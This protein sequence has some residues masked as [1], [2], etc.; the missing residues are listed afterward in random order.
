MRILRYFAREIL[1]A[2]IVSFLVFF[3]LF[4]L[5]QILLL[6]EEILKRKAPV[7]QVAILILASL[8]SI[9]ALTAPFA[10]LL[11][12]LLSMGRL[13]GDREIL[14]AQASGIPHRLLFLPSLILGTV[15]SLGSYL[16]NDVLLP[17]GAI[18]FNKV[19]RELIFSTPELELGSYSVKFYKNFFIVTGKVEGSTVHGI[20]LL[21]RTARDDQQLITAKTAQLMNNA[22]FP[23]V[24]TLRFEDVVGIVPDARR[25]GAYDYYT[26][27]RLDYNIVLRDLVPSAPTLGPKEMRSFDLARQISIKEAEVARVQGGLEAALRQEEGRLRTLWWIQ[28]VSSPASIAQARS[29]AAR[30]LELK[31]RDLSDQVLSSWKTEYYQ[32]F[33]IPLACLCFV[34]LAYPLAVLLQRRGLTGIIGLGLLAAVVYWA[35]LLLARTLALEWGWWPEIALF[36]PNFLI[37]MAGAPLLLRLRR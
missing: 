27:R 36:L 30:I 23:G 10:T 8:P 28:G 35:T 37:L 19:Y 14:A 3:F 7:G 31:S 18:T 34:F 1:L 29:S 13:A 17:Q 12:I 24:L 5:N 15:F 20:S 6:A 26:A 21:D 16:A 25:P 22:A 2:F 32:K 33:S 11:G 4:F 9:L